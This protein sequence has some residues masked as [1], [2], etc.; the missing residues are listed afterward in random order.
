MPSAAPEKGSPARQ[1]LARIIGQFED[2]L[3]AEKE[4]GVSTVKAS[5][6]LVRSLG[7][8]ILQTSGPAKATAR[9]TDAQPAGLDLVFISTEAPESEADLLLTRMIQ[10]MGYAR[11]QV[12]VEP[13][14]PDLQNRIRSLRPKIIVPL[15]DPALQALAIPEQAFARGQWLKWL[16][17]DVLPTH[18]PA[19]LVTQPALKKEAWLD[20]QAVL[21][22]LGR[23]APDVGKK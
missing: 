4:N 10:A 6:A 3:L 22:K 2:W 11:N 15:G 7:A 20:L 9:K 12:A 1:R 18:S 5:P 19:H 16:T 21:S 8:P 23:K 14:S 13:V 17:F